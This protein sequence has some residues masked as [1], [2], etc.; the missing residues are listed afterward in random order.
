MNSTHQKYFLHSCVD[1]VSTFQPIKISCGIL[2]VRNRHHSAAF[3]AG[4]RC[5]PEF[6]ELAVSEVEVGSVPTKQGRSTA[7]ALGIQEHLRFRK[8][9]R[10]QEQHQQKKKSKKKR[11]REDEQV[12]VPSESEMACPTMELDGTDCD[13]NSRKSGREIFQGKRQVRTSIELGH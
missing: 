8:S 6:Y 5:L 1:S 10:Q 4:M 7:C 12:P 2:P 11:G 9:Q 3:K 13:S